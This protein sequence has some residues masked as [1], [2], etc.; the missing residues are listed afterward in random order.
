MC[1]SINL[2]THTQAPAWFKY[3]NLVICT[4]T[5]PVF[6]VKI[7]PIKKYSSKNIFVMYPEMK[8]FCNLMNMEITYIGWPHGC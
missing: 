5:D 3:I 4:T 2:I 7:I 8:I 6:Q 1:I